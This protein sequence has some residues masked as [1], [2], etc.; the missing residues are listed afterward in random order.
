[1][2]AAAEKPHSAGYDHVD[3]DYG[4]VLGD[5]SKEKAGSTLLELNHAGDEQL[6]AYDDWF[7]KNEERHLQILSDP[8]KNLRLIM[9]DGVAYKNTLDK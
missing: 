5:S 7:A 1:M 6:K 8:E 9:K 4:K 2:S 3:P